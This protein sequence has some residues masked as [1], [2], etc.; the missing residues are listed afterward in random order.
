MKEYL[1]HL[2]NEAGV[3]ARVPMLRVRSLKTAL[4][5]AG[6][7]GFRNYNVTEVTGRELKRAATVRNEVLLKG[8]PA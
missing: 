6:A 8:D 3:A 2:T 4:N 5:L 7:H 1:V